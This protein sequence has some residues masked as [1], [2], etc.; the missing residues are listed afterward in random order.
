MQK[1][2]RQDL[3]RRIERDLV[4]AAD[5]IHERILEGCTYEEAQQDQNLHYYMQFVQEH[6]KQ[7]RDLKQ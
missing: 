1:L 7:L 4:R 6:A 2:T 3:A 5:I